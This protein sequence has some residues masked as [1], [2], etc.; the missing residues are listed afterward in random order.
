[1]PPVQYFSM[2]SPQSIKKSNEDRLS[3]N[4]QNVSLETYLSPSSSGELAQTLH[5]LEQHMESFERH[6]AD[7]K[8]EE[9]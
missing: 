8:F 5:H 9:R 2:P 7:E 3:A 1:M 4:L 6:I